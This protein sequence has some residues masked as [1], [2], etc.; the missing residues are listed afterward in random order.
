M[1]APIGMSAS[2]RA[3]LALTLCASGLTA[4]QANT[5]ADGAAPRPGR[6]DFAVTLDDKPI[7]R[8]RFELAGDPATGEWTLKSQA[9]YDVKILGL[10][11]YTY[12]HSATERWRAGC[13]AQL[14]ARTDDNGDVTSVQAAAP[15]GSEPTTSLRIAVRSDDRAIAAAA[16]ASA[17][18]D[19]RGCQTSYAYW[20]PGALRQRSQL[21]NPQTGRLDPVQ[22][23]ALP[24]TSL[25][26]AGQPVQAQ[27]WRLRTPK[28]PVDVWSA[29]DGRWIGLD[30]TVSGDRRLRYR[31]P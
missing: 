10:T 21:L 3:A 6:W 31:L 12:R 1:K 19:A 15:A 23:S 29:A 5:P 22:G 24:A 17:G 28:G 2:T 13:L 11:V 8:H 16:A 20:N 4:A 27:G 7:G 25:I 9:E 26:V 30:A 14:E 18:Q